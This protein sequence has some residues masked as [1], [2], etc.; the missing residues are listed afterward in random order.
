MLLRMCVEG[1]SW[2]LRVAG[3]YLMDSV[4]VRATHVSTPTGE[5]GGTRLQFLQN[6]LVF[7][8]FVFSK[9]DNHT[10]TGPPTHTRLCYADD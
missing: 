10:V 5:S 2:K 3:N 4:R 1:G 6:C 9:N 7:S 8:C